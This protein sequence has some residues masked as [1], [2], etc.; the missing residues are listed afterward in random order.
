MKRT[1]R[2][3]QQLTFNTGEPALVPFFYQIAID[4]TGYGPNAE[5]SG[6]SINSSYYP[7]G[8]Y[9]P[10]G[11]IGGNPLY[12]YYIFQSLVVGAWLHDVF[13]QQYSAGG[14]ITDRSGVYGY[15]WIVIPSLYDIVIHINPDNGGAIQNYAVGN[16]P[17]IDRICSPVIPRDPNL[18]F[19]LGAWV[20]NCPVSTGGFADIYS[21]AFFP[22]T[23]N[24]DQVNLLSNLNITGYS[25][26]GVMP[27]AVYNNNNMGASY[28]GSFDNCW[29]PNLTIVTSNGDVDFTPC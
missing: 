7:A 19:I 9:F 5:I 25:P 21:D 24:D 6:V 26:Y 14:G 28:D 22:P 13:N 17:A 18:D 2:N 12:N 10:I 15:G 23:M 8:L 20:K 3:L 11:T 16:Y 29:F 27:F 1:L 4:T